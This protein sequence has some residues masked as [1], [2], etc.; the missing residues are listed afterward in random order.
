MLNVLLVESD[1]NNTLLENALKSYGVDFLKIQHIPL[2]LTLVKE[3]RP[4]VIIFN[5]DTP[6]EKL[7]SD[8]HTLDQQ[9]P[10]PVIM[11]ASDGSSETINKAIK[12]EVNA[13]IVDGLPCQHLN[14]IIQVAI[15]R[16]KQRQVL[17]NALEDARTQL[18]DRKQI[19]RAKAILIKTQNFT[20]E[21]AYHTLRKLAMDRNI[22]LGEMSRNVIAMAELL[23]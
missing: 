16:F 10:L 7:I 11:F 22:T 21:E 8:L 20:E 9:L 1:L 12:A 18:E 6:S 5:V 19:D 3:S 2:F 15:A 4:D 14:S 13:F 17:K 23:K